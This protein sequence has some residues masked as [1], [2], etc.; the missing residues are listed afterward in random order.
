MIKEFK[1]WFAFN[2]PD[3][4][5]L[6]NWDKFRIQFKAEAPIRYGLNRVVDL[7]E[8]RVINKIKDAKWWIKHRTTDK[9][10]L[11]N[12]GLTPGYYDADTRMLNSV[13]SILK[14]FIEIE[15]ARKY[16]FFY[17]WRSKVMENKRCGIEYMKSFGKANK[18]ENPKYLRATQALLESYDYW[19]VQ[20]PILVQ[21]LDGFLD[22][23]PTSDSNS[24]KEYFKME[25]SL[26]RQDT[27]CL[28]KI[29]K[30][31]QFMWT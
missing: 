23:H 17:P 6:E 8:Y 4:A 13:F 1:S 15:C 25:R 5:T 27:L 9:Y 26:D 3:S 29:V 16:R 30:H 10:H 22:A 21:E 20:R 19:T 24:V 7:F 18:K 28:Q 2:P 14:D 31:R 12:T 11:I